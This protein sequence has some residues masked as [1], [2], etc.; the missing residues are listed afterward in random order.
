MMAIL[1][2]KKTFCYKKFSR[3]LFYSEKFALAVLSK[4]HLTLRD[5]GS[6]FFAKLS[7]A[8]SIRRDQTHLEL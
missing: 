3:N 4:Q 8:A 6:R 7:N 1:R 5:A 2:R